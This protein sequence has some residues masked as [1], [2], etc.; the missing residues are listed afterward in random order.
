[1]LDPGTSLTVVSL[2]IQ[3]AKGLLAYDELWSDAE[4]DIKVIQASILWTAKVF[5]QLGI[6]LQKEHLQA[7]TV[8]VIQLT[9]AACESNI[10]KLQVLLDKIRCDKSLKALYKFKTLNRKLLYM[11]HNKTAKHPTKVLHDLKD[12]LKL[13]INLLDL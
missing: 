11:L 4:H 13:A 6:T 1:M 7:D 3:T 12:E 8:S 2:A 5:S 10:S 9:V